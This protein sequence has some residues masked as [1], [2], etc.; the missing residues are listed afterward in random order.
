MMIYDGPLIHIGIAIAAGGIGAAILY[1]IG[2][3]DERAECFS[4]VAEARRECDGLRAALVDAQA[5]IQE[6]GTEDPDDVE[7]MA[8]I[9]KLSGRIS[10]ALAR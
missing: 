2:R 9:E 4:L 6:V 1:F 3:S 5:F 8:Q 10:A 7:T